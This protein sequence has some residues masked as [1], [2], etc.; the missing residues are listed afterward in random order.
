M[1]HRHPCLSTLT[2]THTRHAFT[3]VE[4]L[5]VISIIGVLLA[6]LL[7]SLSGARA[8]ARTTLCM[9]NLRQQGI[10]M[11]T[12]STDFKNEIPQFPGSISNAAA[13]PTWTWKRSINDG[14]G[15]LEVSSER[16]WF[17]YYRGYITDAIPTSVFND[18]LLH[19]LGAA[20][21]VFDC[22]TTNES[23]TY[24]STRARRTFDYRRIAHYSDYGTTFKS[25]ALASKAKE[26]LRTDAI[27]TN[28]MILVD[29]LTRKDGVGSGNGIDYATE[30][31]HPSFAAYP[32]QVN[33]G[34]FYSNLTT[35][36]QTLIYNNPNSTHGHTYIKDGTEGGHT[37]STSSTPG[38]HHAG[39]SNVLFHSGHVR[40][41]PI[42]TIVP[43]FENP[44]SASD[45]FTLAPRRVID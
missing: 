26:L 11:A 9:T 45:L 8:Q 4:L 25:R 6:L 33:S 5:V 42:G 14:S 38:I 17:L 30:V 20:V 43:A 12:Y 7:P 19:R 23:T 35:T 28:G 41:L 24:V 22:P 18:R 40:T 13:N 21:K 15:L 2:R 16:E 36:N 34:W 37:G 32:S 44:A 29:A 10:G 1:K 39:G 3:L 27:P 31:D